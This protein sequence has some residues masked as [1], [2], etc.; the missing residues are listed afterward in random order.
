LK[1]GVKEAGCIRDLLKKSN[2]IEE[3][4]LN[5]N[6]FGV[7]GAQIIADGLKVNQSLRILDLNHNRIRNKG[8]VFIANAILGEDSQS[9]L[10]TLYIK[11][12]FI[13]D[14]SFK[15]IVSLI[16][17]KCGPLANLANQHLRGLFIAGND[18]SIFE[19]KR[20]QKVILDRRVDLFVDGIERIKRNSDE[21]LFISGVNM[22][23][24]SED[25]I[26]AKL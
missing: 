8:A 5:G 26:V 19:L 9:R 18:T 15:Q 7:E 25:K 13:G 14:K 11:S 21:C 20:L 1:L 22:K 4:Y 2:Q 24:I 12:N 16:L 6:S 23:T 3:L 10:R 17:N